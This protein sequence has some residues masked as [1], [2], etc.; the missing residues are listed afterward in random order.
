MPWSGSSFVENVVASV[1]AA[2]I[3]ALIVAI[4]AI[5][6]KAPGYMA[7]TVGIVVFAAGLTIVN[8]LRP[9]LAD[10][11]QP[12][13]ASPV[14]AAGDTRPA[15]PG[16]KIKPPN[17]KLYAEGNTE[18]DG[19]TLEV[20]VN[21][22]GSFVIPETVIRN[23]GGSAAQ[24]FRVRLFLCHPVQTGSWQPTKSHEKGYVSQF[25]WATLGASISPGEPWSMPAFNGKFAGPVPSE[26][27]ARIG[28]YYKEQEKPTAA[29]FKIVL[30]P[31]P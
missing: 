17:L 19:S 12:S 18:L 9:M 24:D 11:P 21:K 22:D 26:M 4:W 14:I 2:G 8:Q 1:V 23:I 15:P 31:T 30:R 3:V 13:I 5:V 6:R 7:A 28:V 16:S 25:F 29:N 27:S 10:K 20:A